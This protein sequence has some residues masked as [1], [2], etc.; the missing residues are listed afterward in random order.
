MLML[1]E[2]NWYQDVFV[3]IY[4]DPLHSF[5]LLRRLCDV[6]CQIQLME[7]HSIVTLTISVK[8]K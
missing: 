8:L 1:F 7:V 4:M 3:N 6:N 5:S 2:Y